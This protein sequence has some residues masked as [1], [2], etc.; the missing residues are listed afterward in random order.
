[1]NRR[2]QSDDGALRA[3]DLPSE[4][5]VGSLLTDMLSRAM[6]STKVATGDV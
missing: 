4:L 1:M 5:I 2:P 3:L 6:L